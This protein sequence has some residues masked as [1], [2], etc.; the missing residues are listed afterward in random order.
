MVHANKRR[1]ACTQATF[2]SNVNTGSSCLIYAEV[3]DGA[4][5]TAPGEQRG[6]SARLFRQARHRLPVGQELSLEERR[7]LTSRKPRQEEGRELART[8]SPGA[9][10]PADISRA[11]PL[12]S[13]HSQLPAGPSLLP[14]R[15]LS[16]PSR[17]AAR[18]GSQRDGKDGAVT[19]G[20]QPSVSA[21]RPRPAPWRSARR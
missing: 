2:T 4:L 7:A 21:P 11:P 20:T 6:Q 18:T 17:G 16:P 3:T 5:E 14:P 9:A 15:V 8:P 19:A 1:D 12:A 10:E 13:Q